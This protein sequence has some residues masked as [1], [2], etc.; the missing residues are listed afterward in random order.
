MASSRQR[1]ARSYHARQAAIAAAGARAVAAKIEQQAPWAEVVSSWAAYQ[2]AAAT[3]SSRTITQVLGAPP[4]GAVELLAG[5]S[6]LGFDLAEPLIATIDA[7]VPAPAE[8]MPSPW[9]DDDTSSFLRSVELLVASEIQDA[10]RAAAQLEM[11]AQPRPQE[12]IRLLVPP[13][14]KRCAVLAGRIYR[15]MEPFDRHPGCDCEHWPVASLDEALA[16]GLVVDPMVLVEQGLIRD[17]S[18]SDRQALLEGADLSQIVN[19][20][21][22][23]SQPG[24]TN[25]LTTTLYGRRVKAT[26]FGTT[27][28]A[29]WRRN[30]PSRPVR[31]RPEA[32][33]RIVDAE[34]GGDREQAR[35]LLG[36][37]GW[38][39]S[40]GA[41]GRGR[42]LAAGR[43]NA[44][45]GGGPGAPRPVNAGGA[46]DDARAAARELLRLAESVEPATTEMVRATAATVGG[47]LVRLDSRL[48]SLDSLTRK[49]ITQ[50]GT[51][52]MTAADRA[53][54]IK[55]A[56]RYTMVAPNERYWQIVD[57]TV[58]VLSAA[59]YR[60]VKVPAGWRREGYRGMNLALRSPSGVTFELQVH[61]AASLAVAEASHLIYEE[62]RADGIA[63]ARRAELERKI[64]EMYL[65]VAM[66][67]PPRWLP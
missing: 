27:K 44:G 51:S 55:D 59:G 52:G 10:S 66:P 2:L 57:Q 64:I 22:G 42:S 40:A 16:D 47:D 61:T 26:T 65:A 13:S 58:A 50:I 60:P 39:P 34:F 45:R 41:P 9:W 48:K 25:A 53:A 19:A 28:R 63:P 21:R 11:L 20:T 12:F 29:Q 7:R 32:I 8:A 56:L 5:V 33:Y 35:R 54:E 15:D 31:L 3:A 38:L 30:N 46:D 1:Q 18:Q 23:T 24:I 4:S 37:Y 14:C 62:A 6:S 49:L 17:L 43:G 36:L 67:D